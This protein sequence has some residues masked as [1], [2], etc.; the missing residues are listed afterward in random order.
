M[1]QCCRFGRIDALVNAAQASR[2]VS[3]LETTQADMDLA[4]STGFWPTR[5]CAGGL[6]SPA[7][8]LGSVINFGGAAGME[9][10][11]TQASYGAAK[12]SGRW[13]K[14]STKAYTSVASERSIQTSRTELGA[15]GGHREGAVARMIASR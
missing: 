13:R 10:L 1:R 14:T 6:S 7:G 8:E 4:M 9:G 15:V 3:V 2:Q 11:P 12:R 5:C